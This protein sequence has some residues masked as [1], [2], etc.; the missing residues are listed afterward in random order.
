[1]MMMMMM[2]ITFVYPAYLDSIMKDRIMCIDLYRYH[3]KE[4]PKRIYWLQCIAVVTY[5]SYPT[6]RRL[7][8]PHVNSD[9]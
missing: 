2:M 3:Y 7:R 1:M 6:A 5:F 9:C 4:C 8:K